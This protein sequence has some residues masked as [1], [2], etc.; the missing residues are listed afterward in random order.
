MSARGSKARCLALHHR[1]VA[2]EVDDG[3]LRVTIE[4]DLRAPS[5][6]ALR[7][8]S[9]LAKHDDVKALGAKL[10]RPDADNWRG[11]AIARNGFSTCTPP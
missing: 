10:K 7:L 11:H 6:E 8:D 3:M 9:G 2:V 1:A 5:A 4:R